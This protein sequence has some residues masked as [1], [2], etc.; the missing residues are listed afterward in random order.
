MAYEIEFSFKGDI[1]G[2]KELALCIMGESATAIPT[3]IL[4]KEQSSNL[5]KAVVEVTKQ[6]MPA[7]ETVAT[8]VNTD[9]CIDPSTGKYYT[10]FADMCKVLD[11]LVDNGQASDVKALLKTNSLNGEYG[12]VPSKAWGSVTK[13]AKTLLKKN[14]VDKVDNV[15]DEVVEPP[16]KALTMDELKIAGREFM[17]TNGKEAMGTIL[18]N[19]GVGNI[20]SLDQGQYESFMN[21]LQGAN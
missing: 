13:N 12:G 17:K 1:R 15:P 2:L 10:M 16:K 8:P 21:A 18:A 11:A 19:F 6:E 9:S 4:T 14:K 20:S 5:H 7:I 3:P